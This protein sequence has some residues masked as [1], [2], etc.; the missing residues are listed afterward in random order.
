[1]EVSRLNPGSIFIRAGALALIS[2]VLSIV[3]VAQAV[4]VQPKISRVRPDL[5]CVLGCSLTVAPT[6][7]AVNFALVHGGVATGSTSISI[8]TTLTGISLL[9]SLKLY[10]YFSSSAAALTDGATTPD[11]IPS[12][13]VLGKMPT[14]SPTTFTPFTASNPIGPAGAGLLLY[15]AGSVVGSGR[16]DNLSLEIDLSNPALA[17]L[18]AGTYTG[19]LV[20]VA[21]VL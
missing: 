19:T 9:S 20:L 7:M 6:P 2:I 15:S 12:Y 11:N 5:L 1:L 13:A 4:R 21:Q 14:G 3:G 16:T 18:P 10:G 8:V 17:Q